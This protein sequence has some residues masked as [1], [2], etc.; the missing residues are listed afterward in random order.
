[1]ECL[2]IIMR[3]VMNAFK[4]IK[5]PMHVIMEEDEMFEESVLGTPDNLSE[6]E[7]CPSNDLSQSQNESID[8]PMRS[9]SDMNSAMMTPVST[10]FDSPNGIGMTSPM[11]NNGNP[12]P[13]MTYADPEQK[14]GHI[15]FSILKNEIIKAFGLKS[16]SKAD[17][18]LDKATFIARKLVSI[19]F[20]KDISIEQFNMFVDL[21][22]EKAYLISFPILLESFRKLGYFELERTGFQPFCEF[23]LACLTEVIE[24]LLV[25]SEEER[26]HSPDHP[27]HRFHLLH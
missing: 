22:K 15:L 13:A 10:H 8:T 18:F 25:C 16:P 26:E 4:G 6:S 21:L 1:M 20:G 27:K 7:I 19:W 9:N 12:K 23:M 5:E 3:E 11:M 17:S 2:D 14:D 24:R